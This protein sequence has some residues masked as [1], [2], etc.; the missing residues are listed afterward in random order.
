[1][2]RT[3]R[4]NKASLNVRL[5]AKIIEIRVCLMML[6]FKQVLI[7]R[8]DVDYEV[9]DELKTW[10]MRKNINFSVKEEKRQVYIK[11]QHYY[12]HHHATKNCKILFFSK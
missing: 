5:E 4:K 1:M 12:H 3:D 6:F 7:E 10:A 2:S 11:S 9:Y 8:D